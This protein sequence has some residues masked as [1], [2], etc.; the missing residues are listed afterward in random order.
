VGF[1]WKSLA[2][3][4]GRVLAKGSKGRQG[5]KLLPFTGTFDQAWPEISMESLWYS[6]PQY[7]TERTFYLQVGHALQYKT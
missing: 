6:G 4:G 2:R 7:T 1:P 5:G 3:P